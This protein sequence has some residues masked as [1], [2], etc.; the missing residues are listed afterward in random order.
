MIETA[1]KYMPISRANGSS[2]QQPRFGKQVEPGKF[3]TSLFRFI[4]NDIQD[5]PRHGINSMARDKWL[6]NVWKLEPY[7]AGVINSVTSIDKNRGW[8]IT[9]GRN[10][11][12]RFSKMLHERFF[13]APD[14]E[15]WRMSFGGSALSYYT[16]DIGSITEIGRDGK[17]GPM[18]ELYFVDPARCALTGS[19]R[20]PLKYHPVSGTPQLWEREDYFR[21]TSLPDTN[22]TTFGLGLS[23]LSRC[24]ELAKIM[25]GIYQYDNE[26]LLNRAPRGL[27]LLKGITENQWEEAMTA[28]AAKLD[29][30]EKQYYGA[31]NVLAGID[32]G[33]EL[34]AQ[35]ISLSSLPAEFNQQIFTDLLMFGYALCFGYD[36]REFWPVSG[37]T[38]GTATETETQHR[39]A[40]GKGGL[41]FTLGF[42]EKLQEELPDTVQFEFEE[43]DR[44]GELANAEVE[45]AQAEVVTSLY[46]S[47]LRE[48]VPLI[49]RNEGRIMLAERGIIDPA[50]TENE[51][52]TVATDTEDVEPKSEATPSP[53]EEESPNTDPALQ[54]ERVQRAIWKYPDEP[55]VQYRFSVVNNVGRHEYRTLLNPSQVRR[56]FYSFGLMVGRMVRRQAGAF[57]DELN[58]YQDQINELSRQAN[59]GEIG[60][61]EYQTRLDS[62]T[63]AVLALALTRGI[64][65]QNAAQETLTEAALSVLD[66]E[67]IQE[68]MAV[69][70]DQALLDEAFPEDALGALVEDV[71]GSLQS[72]LT[73][74]IFNGVY[75]GRAQNLL[76]RL[77]MWGLT[78]QGLFSFGRMI[79]NPDQLFQWR[80]GNTKDACE[81]C[82][83]LDNQVHTGAEWRAS[84]WR[85]QGRNL[86]CTG[87]NCRCGVF[88]V[89]LPAAGDF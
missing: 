15:G 76:E 50:W 5:E 65:E 61:Q 59:E 41:D 28:R 85:P 87:H 73:A 4:N 53:D 38:L 88:E 16:S 71:D 49:S 24:I 72:T 75:T 82:L 57:V 18:D 80:R 21:I 54:N 45:Q 10:Q 77:T 6:R 31:V 27:L 39:K 63:I 83:R 37:G 64:G 60:E 9:G 29:G 32:P 40:G 12:R 46:E 84:G 35:L 7:L 55:I 86:E 51:E 36:P 48:A 81:D 68:S 33:T 1:T 79:G 74:D 67:N 11:V 19:F 44:D 66:G 62:L 58:D 3:F 25:I 26:M 23:A 89:D 14:L 43:R 30:D 69:L 20:T 56:R 42:A 47:G 78:A 52:E 13:F 34:E 70:T 22:E 8:T 17:G 2:S